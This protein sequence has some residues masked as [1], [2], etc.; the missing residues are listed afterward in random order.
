MVR[1]VSLE[2]TFEKILKQKKKKV[3]RTEAQEQGGIKKKWKGIREGMV[4]KSM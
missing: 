2:E 1:E 4:A 3:G